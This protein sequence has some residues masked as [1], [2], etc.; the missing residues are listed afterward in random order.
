MRASLAAVGGLTVGLILGTAAAFGAVT[1]P[2]LK[3]PVEHA[4]THTCAEEDSTGCYWN[5]QV[6]GDGL[7]HSFYSI[8]VGNKQCVVYWDGDYNLANG[9]CNPLPG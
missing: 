2:V 3:G 1:Q 9:H 7:G 6:Q 4:V 5:A 8:R